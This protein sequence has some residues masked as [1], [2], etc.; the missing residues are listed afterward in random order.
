MPGVKS[1]KMIYIII[2]VVIAIASVAGVNIDEILEKLPIE[3]LSTNPTSD[4]SLQVHFVDVGQGDCTLVI[5][6]GKTL[7]IDA[8]ENGHETDVI[9]YLRS[10][11]IEKLD[12]I[13]VT[14]Q[15]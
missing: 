4:S 9:N 3:T 6:N 12:Y 2:A 14:N 11:N 13:I 7:L 8:G 5:C 1:K 15:H 10:Q